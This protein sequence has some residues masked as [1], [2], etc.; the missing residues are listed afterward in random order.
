MPAAP[1]ATMEAPPPEPDPPM[2]AMPLPPGVNVVENGD[3]ASGDL[4]WRVDD[5]AGTPITHSTDSG[6]LCV[7]VSPTQPYVVLRWPMDSSMGVKLAQSV[8]QLTYDAWSTH[9][10]G[11]VFAAKIGAAVEPYAEHFVVEVDLGNAT[12]PY[13]HAFNPNSSATTGV[14]FEVMQNQLE[15]EVCIDNVSLKGL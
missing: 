1:M 7:T 8:Y 4:Y 6:A 13:Y 15:A 10:E 14:A 11:V 2:E 12:E 9:P 5:G 3:F